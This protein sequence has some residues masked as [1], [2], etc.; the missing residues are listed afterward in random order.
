M[1]HGTPAPYIWRDYLNYTEKKHKGK[2]T[3]VNFRDKEVLGWTAHKE[4]F[5]IKNKKVIAD[6]Y[7]DLFYKHIILRHS[8]ETCYFTN[9]KRP[10]DI[11]LADFWGWEEVSPKF[12]Q[13]DKGVSLV[14]I[15]TSKG[16][17]IFN[18]I[19]AEINKIETTLEIA[20]KLNHPLN[21]PSVASPQ[22]INFEKDYAAQGFTYVAKKY[23]NIGLLYKMKQRHPF[24]A[25]IIWN[26]NNR[27]INRLWKEKK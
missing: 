18:N 8:C 7:T 3:S 15:N 22:R 21:M 24:I 12:N 6:T 23:G 10:S 25:K 17:N 11:T 4:S 9:T 13:D 27:I 2:A 5:I 16:I 1:C 20:R 19:S 26:I 14:L